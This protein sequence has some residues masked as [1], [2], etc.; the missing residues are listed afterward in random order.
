MI[1]VQTLEDINLYITDGKGILTNRNGL[2]SIIN[3]AMQTFDGKFL[4]PN[5]I[6][7]IVNVYYHLATTQYFTDGNKRTACLSLKVNFEEL[8]YGFEVRDTVLADLTMKVATN[9][10]D[11]EKCREIIRKYVK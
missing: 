11:E 9:K 3:S 1:S 5:D 6:D 10:I 7:R 2:D 8:G 4:I